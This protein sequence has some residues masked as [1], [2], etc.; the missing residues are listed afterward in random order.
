MGRKQSAIVF[1]AHTMY[2]KNAKKNEYKY[3]REKKKEELFTPNVKEK[4]NKGKKKKKKENK[5]RRNTVER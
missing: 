1:N 5:E 4:I 2:S 3:Q